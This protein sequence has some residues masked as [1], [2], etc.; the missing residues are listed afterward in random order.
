LTG[1]SAFGDTPADQAG[2]DM[3]VRLDMTVLDTILQL[4]V[5]S[6][7]HATLLRA[8]QVPLMLTGHTQSALPLP[9]LTSEQ[10]AEIVARLVPATVQARLRESGSVDYTIPAGEGRPPLSITAIG[11]TDDI[12]LE[13]RLQSAAVGA[14]AADPDAS[15]GR[16]RHPPTAPARTRNRVGTSRDVHALIAQ[17][18]TGGETSLFLH[19]GRPPAIKIDGAIHWLDDYEPMG[20]DDLGRLLIELSDDLQRLGGI[21]RDE[22]LSWTVPDL[23]EVECR[24]NLAPPAIQLTFRIA[25]ARPASAAQLRIPASIATMCL[26]QYGLLVVAGLR[27]SALSRT[28]HALVDLVNRERPHHIIVL[29]RLSSLRHV[30]G[31]AY[32]SDRSVTGD[33]EAWKGALAAALAEAPDV[34]VTELVPSAEALDLLMAHAAQTLVI[35]QVVAPSSV[36]ALQQLLRLAGDGEAEAASRMADSLAAVMAQQEVKLRGAGTATLY[37]VV[38]GTPAVRDLVRQRA[39]DQLELLLEGGAEGVIAMSAARA[40]LDRARRSGSGRASSARLTD[41][42]APEGAPRAMVA[43]G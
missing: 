21:E 23:A 19:N 34:L 26:E 27:A 1:L 15:R 28:C 18:A 20:A 13:V 2:F 3:T 14:P 29:E 36:A 33:E 35:A 32:L 24:A 10:M 4:L 43:A 42:A 39:F 16:D 6:G 11:S 41:S 31:P 8:A 37:E 7:G 22:M 38:P 9:P 25:S 40:E 17:V 5:A 12:W 30:K